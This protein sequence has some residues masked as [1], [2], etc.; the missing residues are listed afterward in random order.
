MFDPSKKFYQSENSGFRS[1]P[2]FQEESNNQSKQKYRFKIYS[3]NLKTGESNSNQDIA[4]ELISIFPKT[5]RGF[6]VALSKYGD[7]HIFSPTSD[8]FINMIM[9][10]FID[11][12]DGVSGFGFLLLLNRQMIYC[13]YMCDLVD[14]KYPSFRMILNY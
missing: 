8:R 10:G 5:K 13:L 3:I 6:H 7:I 1:L 9:N 14:H 4:D 2:G 11:E 12:R